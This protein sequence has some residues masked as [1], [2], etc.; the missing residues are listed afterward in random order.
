MVSAAPTTGS[1]RILPLHP[2][3]GARIVVSVIPQDEIRPDEVTG[4]APVGDHRLLSDILSGCFAAITSCHARALH[5]AQ[6]L[7]T[8]NVR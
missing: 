6:N 2:E 8:A 5:F 1:G 7:K 4:G 3:Q